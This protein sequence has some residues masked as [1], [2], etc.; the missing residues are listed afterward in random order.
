MWRDSIGR[1][2]PAGA[3]S[4]R[5]RPLSRLFLALAVAALVLGGSLGCSSTR[6]AHGSVSAASV[7]PAG[8]LLP[9]GSPLPDDATC[10]ARVQPA[11]EV[12]PDNA[13]Y[14]MTRGTQEHLTGP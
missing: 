3:L 5:W 6:F 8:S 13:P 14:N 10:A 7:L 12:R 11:S 2:D 9:P 4:A 1:P